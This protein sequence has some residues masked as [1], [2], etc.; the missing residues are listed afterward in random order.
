MVDQAFTTLDKDGSGKLDFDEF[1]VALRVSL[2]GFYR[3]WTL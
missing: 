2:S 1:L 3:L